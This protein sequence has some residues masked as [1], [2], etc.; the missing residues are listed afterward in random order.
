MDWSATHA[1]FIEVNRIVV[2]PVDVVDERGMEQRFGMLRVNLQC[3][4][5]MTSCNLGFARVRLEPPHLVVIFGRLGCLP[6]EP[7]QNAAGLV[8][9]ACGAKATRSM[10]R[11]MGRVV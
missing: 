7:F 11:G 6:L 2:V 3:L 10:Q 5:V 4:L 8:S 1:A 9:M